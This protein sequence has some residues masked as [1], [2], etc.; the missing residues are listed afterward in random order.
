MLI[1]HFFT[2]YLTLQKLK[3]LNCPNISARIAI[4]FM[5]LLTQTSPH[6][7]QLEPIYYVLHYQN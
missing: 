6:Y 7:V 4:C 1:K 5:H 3:N 2:S